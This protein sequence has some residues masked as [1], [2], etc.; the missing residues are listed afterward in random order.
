MRG[1]EDSK[2]LEIAS[3][4]AANKRNCVFGMQSGWVRSRLPKPALALVPAAGA[5][6]CLAANRSAPLALSC[7]GIVSVAAYFVSHYL[8]DG[9]I[10]SLLKNGM[11]G[12]DLSKPNTEK[13]P[14]ALG[15][16]AGLVTAL[17]VIG[18]H[19]FFPHLELFNAATTA[20]T[21]TVLTGFLDDVLDLRW[22][23]KI[24]LSFLAVLPLIVAYNGP[25]NV[26][27]PKPLRD[28]FGLSI[29]LGV[30]YLLYMTIFG[31]FASNSINIYAGVNGLESGQGVVIAIS[32]VLNNAIQLSLPDCDLAANLVSLVVALPFLGSSLALFYH[33]SYPSRVF[34]GDTYTYTAGMTFAVC[35]ILGKSSKTIMLFFVPQF[36]NFMLSLPQ[37]FHL[38]PIP[39]HR[40][41]AY[42]A[43]TDKLHYSTFELNGKRYMNLTLINL[44]RKGA[45]FRLV[46]YNVF[47]SVVFGCLWR[48]ARADAVFCSF[49]ISGVL[50]CHCIWHSLLHERLLLLIQK[51][52]KKAIVVQFFCPCFIFVQCRFA[53][54]ISRHEV[55]LARPVSVYIFFFPLIFAVR[56]SQPG[57]H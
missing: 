37:L 39:R 1:I 47:F 11:F 53:H 31:V 38:L 55:T 24:G 19:P 9:I 29:E 40:M 49:G 32:V 46:S 50:L 54:C 44:V 14:E 51:Q 36:I 17:C 23:H 52:K 34:V 30:L 3:R 12:R 22:K 56:V 15:V 7:L 16:V 45:Q 42:V 25:T 20:I 48:Y 27:V 5:A 6:L 8:I 26:V 35:A 2:W 21:L 41:P 13:I 18:F 10:P 43:N 33:N 57:P 28:V 4:W